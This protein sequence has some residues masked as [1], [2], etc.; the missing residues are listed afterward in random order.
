[1]SNLFGFSRTD[2]VAYDS[3]CSKLNSKLLK[4][5]A[6]VLQVLGPQKKLNTF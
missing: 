2:Y 5:K 6:L 4:G 3:M 1:M